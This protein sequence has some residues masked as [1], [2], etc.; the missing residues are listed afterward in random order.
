MRT[1]FSGRNPW[2]PKLKKPVGARW[3]RRPGEHSGTCGV[4]DTE[5]KQ[6]QGMATEQ[7]LEHTKRFRFRMSESSR[8][9]SIHRMSGHGTMLQRWQTLPTHP[10]CARAQ[11]SRRSFTHA[12]EQSSTDTNQCL[13]SH[14]HKKAF[15]PGNKPTIEDKPRRKQTLEGML[16]FWVSSDLVLFFSSFR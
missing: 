11:S 1:R 2:F 13:N 14:C 5:R 10:R 3:P 6:Q 16:R 4:R 7:C 15:S 8:N 12:S 9:W